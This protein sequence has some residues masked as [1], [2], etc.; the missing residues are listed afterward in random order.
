MTTRQAVEEKTQDRVEIRRDL[1]RLL[2]ELK[3]GKPSEE[4]MSRARELLRDVDATTL[5][6]VEQELIHEGISHEEIRGSLCDIHLGIM[7]ENLAS[8]RINVEAPHPV[9]TFVEEHKIILQS[10]EKV[11]HLVH[12]FEEAE[13]FAEIRDRLPELKDAAHHLVEAESHHQREEEALFPRL[14]S[15]G[16]SEPP[17]VMKMDHVEL[18][19]KKKELYELASNAEGFDFETFKAKASDL[20]DYL[21]EHLGGHIFK[22]DNILYQMA[23]QVLSPEEWNEVKQECDRIGYCCFT[24]EDSR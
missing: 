22:E 2:S 14:E 9:H 3:E 11:K 18:R 15:H 19:E 8:K 24:P 17:R 23:L 16:I 13:D 4:T 12:G 20:G 7:K 6:M 10:L 5:G 1:K 21:S